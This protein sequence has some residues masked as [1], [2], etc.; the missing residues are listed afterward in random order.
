MIRNLAR[1]LHYLNWSLGNRVCAGAASGSAVHTR[2]EIDV[3][4]TEQRLNILLIAD[5]SECIR[6][7]RSAL[8]AS[9]TRC[10][11]LMVGVG[12]STL[13]YL[14][15]EG[16]YAEAPVPDLIL[17][18]AVDAE[19][20]AMAVLKRIKTDTGF[21]SLPIVLLTN[22]ESEAALEDLQLGQ[23]RYTAF[24]PVDLESFLSALN[25]I[26]PSRFM[27]AISLLEN[28]GFVLVRMPEASAMPD[29]DETPDFTARPLVRAQTA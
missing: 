26:Q 7:I 9:N 24:S 11:L 5:N 21:R 15:R 19:P 29:F 27:H 2:T 8:E 10:R 16:P 13:A 1:N 18:D 28:F 14:R 12:P 17:F 23:T 22:S 4:T 25:A 6:S 3:A 20:S